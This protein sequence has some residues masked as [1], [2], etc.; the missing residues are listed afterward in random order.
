MPTRKRVDQLH[1]AQRF[2]ITSPERPWIRL[3]EYDIERGCAV[4]PEVQR[5]TP[6]ARPYYGLYIGRAEII[7]PETMVVPL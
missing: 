2:Y 4:A 5:T 3:V 1:H 7:G 6:D